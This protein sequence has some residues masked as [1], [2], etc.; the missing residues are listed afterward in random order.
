MRAVFDHPR[1]HDLDDPT[2][3]ETTDNSTIAVTPH[4]QRIVADVNNHQGPTLICQGGIHGNEPAGLIAAEQVAQKLT[5]AINRQTIHKAFP[6][7]QGRFLAIAGHLTALN[8][9]DPDLRYFDHD[10]NRAFSDSMIQAARATPPTQRTPEQRE[11]VELLDLYSSLF[12]QTQQRIT[13]MDLHTV[14]SP[15][16]AFAYVEDALPARALGLSLEL[17]LVLGFEEVLPGLCVDYLTNQYGALCVLVEAG[18]HN[19]PHSPVVHEAAIWAVMA[20]QEMIHDPSLLAGFDVHATLAKAA[21]TQ[22][23]RVFDLRCRVPVGSPP[24]EMLDRAQAFTR[25]WKNL[26]PVAKR[27][28]NESVHI[29]RA[30]AD[31]LLFMP[32]RQAIRKPEDDA[33]F[34]IRPICRRFMWLSASLRNSHLA[35]RL[36]WSLP[37]VRNISGK[38]GSEPVTLQVDH[39]VAAIMA[40]DI[41]HLFGYR[42]LKSSPTPYRRFLTR[43]LLALWVFPRALLHLVFRKS[44][45]T[46]DL[47]IVRQHR[48]DCHA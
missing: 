46:E 13:V 5:L 38:D 12:E 25:V 34:V 36:L 8:D 39:A 10:L 4:W 9:Q 41:L 6:V 3:G 20:Q 7:F 43:L 16:P 42:V 44:P 48:L 2:E 47:W 23:N 11:L 17:P 32:N 31:G 28:D 1:Q 35:Q 29:V 33:F 30:P 27:I 40:R 45:P 24:M 26:T 21:K 22:R 15:S 19:D 14:S 37:G 18:L